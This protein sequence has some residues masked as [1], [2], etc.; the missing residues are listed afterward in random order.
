MVKRRSRLSRLLVGI[1]R[2]GALLTAVA[3]GG[4]IA[5]YLLFLRDLPDLHQLA[6]YRPPLTSWVLD[7][8]GMPVGLFSEERRQLVP[9][10]S[11]PRHVTQAFVA[12]EDSAFFEHE[13]LD[14][15]SILRAAWVDLISGEIRQGAST[16]TQQTVKS[17][18]LTPERR[19]SRKIKEMILARRLEERFTKQE[20]LFLYL[21]QIY[22]GGGA[23]GIAEAARTYF[24]KSVQ[25]LSVSEAALLAGLPK[26]PSRYSPSADPH[27][28]ERRRLYVLRRM[29]EEG[30]LDREAYVAAVSEPPV[31]SESPERENFAVARWFTEEVRRS[32]V[33]SLGTD[34]VL[35]GGLTIETTLDLELQRTAVTAVRKGLKQL[36]RRQGWY[37]PVRHVTP[38]AIPL[39]LEQ[40]AQENELVVEGGALVELPATR[41]VFGIV[42]GLE[43]EEGVAQVAFAPGLEGEVHL[44]DVRWARP[45]DPST[46]PVPMERIDAVF[47]IGDVARFQ[48]IDLDL[49]TP[50]DSNDA[51][52]WLL[53]QEPRVEG[54]LL[55]LGVESGDVLAL[56]GGYDF[57]R[58]QFDRA[59]QAR[60]QPGSAFKP[61]TYAAAIAKGY[62]PV[63]ILYDRPLVYSD[64]NSGFTWRPENYG[65]RFLGRILLRDALARSINNAT[66]HLMRDVGVDF[67]IEY[68]RHLG[69][70]SPLERNLSLALGASPVSLLELTRAYATFAA[71]GRRL[72]PRFIIRVL[73]RE[74]EV[75]LENVLL[76]EERLDPA[77]ESGDETDSELEPA[78]APPEPDALQGPSPPDPNQ[79]LPPTDAYLATDL[80]RGVVENPRGTGRRARRLGRPVGGKTGTTNDHGDAWF[81]GFSPEVAAGVWVGYDERQVLGRGETGGRA[82]LPIWIDFMEQVLAERSIRDFPV[83]DGIV[84]TR[85]DGATGL[86][87]DHASAEAYFQ[88]FLAGTEPSEVAS[89]ALRD[90]ESRRLLRRE[91]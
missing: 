40:L 83:P 89:G 41:P 39:E 62:T 80:L 47:Q 24:A 56:V 38:E 37:G 87:A 19:F 74:G 16:I 4:A 50:S 36:D 55:C 21:N 48:L 59:V 15:R 35:Q 81:V 26:A 34:V 45:R 27:A 85:I 66:I 53:H 70:E 90:V 3:A 22:F 58:S 72:F 5:F 67:V 43:V 84:F 10:A 18:L 61:I 78:E 76:G 8:H 25:D 9:L 1:A 11:V 88:P 17:L 91:F 51:Q 28:A 29:L 42:T 13:G 20:I 64:P 82:A 12:S 32:L 30:F 75:V 52:G 68:A 69:I 60:R 14:Y 2:G 54:A 23:W 86:L 49:E 63:S 7:R 77:V 31:V 33:E 44:E 65:R 57:Q 73:D 6:D 79:I 46:R 71:G